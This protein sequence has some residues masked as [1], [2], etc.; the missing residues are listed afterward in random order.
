[1]INIKET[2]KTPSN[3]LQY[4]VDGLRKQSQRTDFRINMRTFGAVG[5]FEDKS[6]KDICY[7]CAATCTIQEI[8]K[9][10]LT[11]DTIRGIDA[12]SMALGFD[13]SELERFEEAIDGARAGHLGRLFHFFDMEDKYFEEYCYRVKLFTGDFKEQLPKMELL[14]ADL[15]EK[16]L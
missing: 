1:M 13:Y 2:V 4:M 9:K 5:F 6:D 15:K 16:G 7:G 14:I 11:I 12:R 8:A 3:A 10:D